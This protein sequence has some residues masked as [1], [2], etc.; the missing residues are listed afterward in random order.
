MNTKC[1][2]I[3]LYILYAYTFIIMHF[4]DISCVLFR[5]LLVLRFLYLSWNI[6]ICLY[7][8]YSEWCFFCDVVV[9]LTVTGIISPQMSQKSFSSVDAERDAAHCGKHGYLG[10]Q[11]VVLSLNKK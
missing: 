2:S 6:I 5:L 3:H 1:T 9:T 11:G 10:Q 4:Q 8:C 7:N